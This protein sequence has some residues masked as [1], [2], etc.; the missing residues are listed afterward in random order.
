MESHPATWENHLQ[1]VVMA[2]NTSVQSSTGYTPFFLMLG[3]EAR[4]PADLV[5]G[6]SPTESSTPAEYARL[7]TQSLQQAYACARA[8]NTIAKVKQKEH[9]D[10]QAHGQAFKAGD[11]VWLHLPYTPRG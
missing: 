10:A 11:S 7:M 8:N 2:Y 3:R 9:H 6:S 4:L 1:K 5:Y